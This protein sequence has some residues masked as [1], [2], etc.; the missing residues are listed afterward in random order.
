MAPVPTANLRR[1]A[2]DVLYR[3]QPVICGSLNMLFLTPVSSDDGFSLG[4]REGWE[5]ATT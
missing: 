3:Q 1:L 5:Q 2:P 4:S